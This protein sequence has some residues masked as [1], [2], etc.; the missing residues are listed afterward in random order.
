LGTFAAL[1][2]FSSDNATEIPLM[3][4]RPSPTRSNNLSGRATIAAATSD[5]WHLSAPI[6]AMIM[7]TASRRAV[8][9]QFTVTKWLTVLGLAWC[10]DHGR[11]LGMFATWGKLR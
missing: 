10:R 3:N 11:A 7:L 1:F 5:Q 4:V 9:G 6:M 8:M 2:W